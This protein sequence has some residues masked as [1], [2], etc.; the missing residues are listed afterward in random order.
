[1]PNKEIELV[2]ASPATLRFL[3][4]IPRYMPE[5][6]GMFPV[7]HKNGKRKLKVTSGFLT[8]M[9]RLK[10]L[11]AQLKRCGLTDEKVKELT[12]PIKSLMRVGHDHPVP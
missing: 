3:R 2:Y 11:E 9:K 7:E 4:K 8:L 1:M 6:Y 12:E 10:A 5:V